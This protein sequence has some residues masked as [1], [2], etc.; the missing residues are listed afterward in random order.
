MTRAEPSIGH[1]FQDSLPIL[2]AY[3]CEDKFKLLM[4]DLN[5][6]IDVF[7]PPPPPPPKPH[8]SLSNE[9]VNSVNVSAS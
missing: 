4:S 3:L 2:S 9:L 7:I 1:E 6:A 8:T 5:T